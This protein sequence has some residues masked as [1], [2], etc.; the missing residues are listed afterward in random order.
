MSTALVAAL[1]Q[2][3]STL[4]P[5]ARLAAQPAWPGWEETAEQRSERYDDIADA[6]HR[7]AFDPAEPPIFAGKYGRLRT[8]T[9][10]LGIAWLES[11]FAR[12]VDLGPCYRGRDGASVRCDSG[13]SACLMQLQIG[14]G[15]TAEGWTQAELFADREKCFRAALHLL[16]KSF[17]ACTRHGSEHALDGYTVGVCGSLIGAARGR[18]RLAAGKRIF[19]LA[20][21]EPR[22]I[23]VALLP[24]TGGRVA[25]NGR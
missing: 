25:S 9:L 20:F 2:A 7:V 19:D 10:L 14:R 24:V 1:V 13:R 23:D 5:P 16:R 3:M 17:A 8:T 12:D 15:V 18:P 6:A 22:H 4:A 21:P 11:G